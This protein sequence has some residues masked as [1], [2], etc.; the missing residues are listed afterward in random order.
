MR[1]FLRAVRIAS[2]IAIGVLGSYLAAEMWPEPAI[3]LIAHGRSVMLN[4]DLESADSISIGV[5]GTRPIFHNFNLCMGGALV[6]GE[7]CP[8]HPV[9]AP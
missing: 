3:A 7:H 5:G 6:W 2:F 8:V 4:I 9:A 1:R